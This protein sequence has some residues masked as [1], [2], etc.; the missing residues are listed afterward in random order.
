MTPR[1]GPVSPESPVH[2]GP[3]IPQMFTLHGTGATP[4]RRR[5]CG[6]MGLRDHRVEHPS[7]LA[8]AHYGISQALGRQRRLAVPKL[9]S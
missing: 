5:C 2:R 1:L 7:R 9:L 3:V 8:T 6:Q 4:L